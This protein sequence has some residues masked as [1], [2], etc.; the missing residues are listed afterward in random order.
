MA[1]TCTLGRDNIIKLLDAVYKKMLT[2][3]PGETFDVNQYINYMYSGFEKAQGRDTAIQY[4]QQIPYI[5]G[6][7]EAQLGGDLTLN[8]PIEKLR[9]VTRSFRNADTGLDAI[10]KYLGIA[11]LTP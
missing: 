1:I 8:M 11:P 7:V 10:E 3:P 9:E 4:I 6:S 2:T 5:I